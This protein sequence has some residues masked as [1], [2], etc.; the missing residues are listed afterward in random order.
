MRIAVAG[1]TGVAGRH[2]VEAAGD[3][4]HD[5]VVLARST[6]V[7]TR[8]GDGLW[9]A[10]DGV[11]AVIDATNAG[12]TEQRG[13]TE[14]FTE[15]AS[16]L[17]RVAAARGVKHLVVLS[18]V[19]ID[20]ARGGY[21]AAKL[22]HEQAMLAGP[23]RATVLRATQFHEFPAQMIARSREGSVARIPNL[24]IQPVAARTV[25]EVLVEMCAQEPRRSS[26][27]LA[28]PEQADLATLAHRFA[29]LL[30]PEIE[31]QASEPSLP[32]GALIPAAG[33]RIEGPS[34][35]QWLRSEDAASI[36]RL[37]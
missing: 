8:S 5:V 6:G 24:R 23:L 34:F 18:I 32:A 26:L 30:R 29:A 25:G 33:A 17:Q 36:A 4:G 10:L 9:E 3:A 13:A 37:P 31:V 21:Y 35:E 14:F 19:G 2:V 16:S 12:T 11:D 20:E 1:G 28:G 7:D 15:S 27:E 22:A